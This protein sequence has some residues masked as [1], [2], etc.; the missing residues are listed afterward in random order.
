MRNHS[1]YA[2]RSF[3]CPWI[4]LVTA[5]PIPYRWE[6]IAGLLSF[7]QSP[8]DNTVARMRIDGDQVNGDSLPPLGNVY[9]RDE[10][11]RFTCSWED[12]RYQY[13]SSCLDNFLIAPRYTFLNAAPALHLIFKKF[14]IRRD[15]PS[16]CVV[17][18]MGN[19][20]MIG[21]DMPKAHRYTLKLKYQQNEQNLHDLLIAP[22][23]TSRVVPSPTDPNSLVLNGRSARTL[24]LAATSPLLLLA[25]NIHITKMKVE[26]NSVSAGEKTVVINEDDDPDACSEDEN[27]GDSDEDMFDAIGNGDSKG[28]TLKPV[29]EEDEDGVLPS[30]KKTKLVKTPTIRQYDAYFAANEDEKYFRM[31]MDDIWAGCE[32]RKDD[33]LSEKIFRGHPPS[34]Y[35]IQ[36]LV[37]LFV[38]SSPRLQAFL[39]NIADQV[40]E[41]DE[42]A[43]AFVNNP[44]EAQLLVV[45]MRLLGIR[46]QAVLSGQGHDARLK[47]IDSFNS[48]LER[49]IKPGFHGTTP[50]DVE[51]LVLTYYMNSGLNLHHQCHNLH[52]VSPP[53]SFAI[54]VQGVGR[55]VRFG[56]KS[57][58]VIISYLMEKTF[59]VQQMANVLK[60]HLTTVAAMV[61]ENEGTDNLDY[62]AVHIS[63]S[64]ID[65]YI[66]YQGEL[67][68][69][70]SPEFKNIPESDLEDI[71]R[72]EKFLRILNAS[73]GLTLQVSTKK[74]QGSIQSKIQS[75]AAFFTKFSTVTENAS[76][77]KKSKMF[78][79]PSTRGP[80]GPPTNP[81]STTIAK[82]VD[83]LMDFDNTIESEPF[84]TEEAMKAAREASRRPKEK[85]TV[86][87]KDKENS[88][89]QGSAAKDN[90]TAKTKAKPAQAAPVQSSDEMEVDADDLPVLQTSSRRLSTD[91]FTTDDGITQPVPGTPTFP[92]S[93]DVHPTFPRSSPSPVER[94]QKRPAL[95]TSSP[96]LPKR[97]RLSNVT[98]IDSD[99][100]LEDNHVEETNNLN[101]KSQR[102]VPRQGFAAFDAADPLA[103]ILPSNAS[104]YSLRT[105]ENSAKSEESTNPRPDGK[106]K[107]KAVKS[108]GK[109]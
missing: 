84:I 81:V 92:P 61:C 13:T 6:D 79:S 16:D 59:N 33:K 9:D 93:D 80:T 14:M 72:E 69:S 43:L 2:I 51:V 28:V 56:N 42:K 39:S 17:D 12:T 47:Y 99:D 23:L 87:G 66:G 94:G 4:T 96:P 101:D 68:D 109:R 11:G 63:V 20:H 103:A 107:G 50:N 29:K 1:S 86:G 22:W 89:E 73:L 62:D 57:D 40:D 97:Q 88:G 5:T 102:K 8:F 108:K 98:I 44:F 85:K 105:R 70:T 32:L 71:T 76:T 24:A 25:E 104:G 35:K 55:I 36:A 31:L 58:C 21:T 26:D 34:K 49:W 41:R 3:D 54:W 95:I 90:G 37:R 46:A 67:V 15:F 38:Q 27:D 18:H 77:P 78:S 10:D 82:K 45:I 30:K 91:L 83:E 65:R 52:A 60:N 75:S 74:S 100:G 53:P 48:P 106:N 64:A 19:T 7:I